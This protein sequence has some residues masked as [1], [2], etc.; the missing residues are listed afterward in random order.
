MNLDNKRSSQNTLPLKSW[1]L[2]W[3][4]SVQ[5]SAVKLA[6]LTVLVGKNSAGKSSLIQS[7][8]LLSG[9]QVNDTGTLQLNTPLF[10]GG[11][12]ADLLN[13]GSYSEVAEGYFGIEGQLMVP[14]L[15]PAIPLSFGRFRDPQGLD[16]KTYSP[17][18]FNFAFGAETASDLAS[19]RMFN[20]VIKGITPGGF[21]YEIKVVPIGSKNLIHE[22][23]DIEIDF[24]DED[25]FNYNLITHALTISF[26]RIPDSTSEEN[27][28]VKT[29][30]FDFNGRNYRSGIPMSLISERT[31]FEEVAFQL[32][33]PLDSKEE[34][35]NNVWYLRPFASVEKNEKNRLTKAFNKSDFFK[36][37]VDML[38]ISFNNDEELL[39]GLVNWTN[40]AVQELVP[41]INKSDTKESLVERSLSQEIF[42]QYVPRSMQELAKMIRTVVEDRVSAVVT[43][44]DGLLEDVDREKKSDLIFE[45][46]TKIHSLR[47][48]AKLTEWD[49]FRHHTGQIFGSIGTRNPLSTF[50]G[51]RVLY[52]GPLRVAPKFA[53]TQDSVTTPNTPVGIKGEATYELLSTQT[54]TANLLQTGRYIVPAGLPKSS[55]PSLQ[56]ATNMWLEFFFGEGSSVS[57]SKPSQF[58]INVRFGDES[59][60]NVGVG[61]S[62]ILPI[63]VLCLSSKP[64][65]LILLEQPELH[66]HPALQQ[67]LADFF[68]EVTRSGRQMIVETHSEYLITRLRLRTVQDPETSEQY[69]IVF[70]ENDEANG[71]TYRP[72]NVDENGSLETWPEGF[73]DEA[74]SDMEQLVQHL[75]NKNKS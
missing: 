14:R 64:G 68:L 25:S 58:G 4:K 48:A 43:S 74:S 5:H 39:N 57:V 38:N 59:L 20:G 71:T 41:R 72:V 70:A 13:R 36:D 47:P 11:T 54:P 37:S 34:S 35:N 19:T 42:D 23:S 17:V 30:N 40:F 63:I 61:V 18:S 1:G 56:E 44:G 73:F 31:V 26:S 7:I 10:K 49:S 51:S 8:L 15:N 62:Q 75:I 55:R 12:M 21:T 32:L 2:S 69:Q 53:Y 16:R 52:L 67:K 46:A 45:L 50:F 65:Q 3:F 27:S 28:A 29:L 33:M 66:L 6:P 9:N 60:T 24:V 22:E